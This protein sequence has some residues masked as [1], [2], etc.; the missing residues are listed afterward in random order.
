MRSQHQVQY[1][2]N[3]HAKFKFQ[4]GLLYCDDFLYVFDGLA[5]F[6][7]LQ[8]RHKDYRPF[9]IQQDHGVCVSRLLMAIALEVCEG[10]CQI[11]RGLWLNKKSFSSASW[12]PSTIVNICIP[13]VSISMDFIMHFSPFNSYN[14]ILVVVDRLTNIVHFI[15]CTKIINGKGTTKSFLDHNFLYHGLP[16]D[17]IFYNWLL[18]AFK[19]KWFFE[20]LGVKVKL[21]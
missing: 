6:Q 19:L 21:S 15:P 2:S 1:F 14:S 18:F 3:D 13:M 9:W 10:I 4:N 16:Q 20:L 7:V 5:W 17:I 11:L 8:A 12:S